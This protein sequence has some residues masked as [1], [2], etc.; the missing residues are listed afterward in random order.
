MSVTIVLWNSYSAVAFSKD[1]VSLASTISQNGR[2]SREH[3]VCDALNASEEQTDHGESI[4]SRLM[5][6]SFDVGRL[7]ILLRRSLQR[8]ISLRAAFCLRRHKWFIINEWFSGE[9]ISFAS[10]N[11]TDRMRQGCGSYWQIAA[12]FL[13]KYGITT[14]RIGSV[15][16]NSNSPLLLTTRTINS[17]DLIFSSKHRD[18]VKL[19]EFSVKR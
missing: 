2:N 14:A 4:F 12:A 6:S 9:D 7:D 3:S 5:L 17:P 8:T 1:D 13:L 18:V 16:G 11:M 10:N 19:F 15:V